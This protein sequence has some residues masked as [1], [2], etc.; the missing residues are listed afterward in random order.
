MEKIDA[1]QHF[2]NYDPVRD[3][4]ITEDMAVLR[5]DYL[6]AQLAPL[7]RHNGFSG[8]VAV[9]A[10][11]SDA[12]TN[13][14][15]QCAA[16][17]AFILGVVG[18]IDL[19]SEKLEEQ[20]ESYSG[21]QKL[22]G[23]RHILQG[24]KQRDLMLQPAFQKGVRILEEEGYTYDLLVFPDQLR[25]ARELAIRFPRQRLILDHLGKPSIRTG[26]IEAWKK[27]IE[28]LAQC[29]NVWCK[30]SGMVTEADLRHWKKED[31]RPCLDAVVSAFGTRRLV[32]G[33]DWPVCLLA[34]SY[35]AVLHLVE[36]Y[37][38]AFS[39]DE[40]SDIFGRNADQFYNLKT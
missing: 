18:W 35:E 33:S 30:I 19:Q 6:P 28:A 34:A 40:Q 8:C 10:G 23:F 3:A 37:F 26:A 9:Q 36:D 2:W 14:L 17:H 1:H 25:F 24:E 27:D 5:K 12:E 7:L 39:P 16:E 4:W 22:K 21:Q 38:S 32:Y 11:Q 31:F 29:E 15:L 13:F 20:L